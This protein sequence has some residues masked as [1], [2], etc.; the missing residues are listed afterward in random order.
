MHDRSQQAGR[1][2][3]KV[4]TLGREGQREWVGR[5]KSEK[6]QKAL[7]EGEEGETLTKRKGETKRER[8]GETHRQREREAHIEEGQREKDAQSK[9]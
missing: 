3:N 2:H 8:V 1:V 5:V 6:E 7:R 4:E 9:G